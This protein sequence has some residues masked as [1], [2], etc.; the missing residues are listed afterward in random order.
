VGRQREQV[1]ARVLWR[2]MRH[3]QFQKR[4][5]TWRFSAGCT[6]KVKFTMDIGVVAHGTNVRRTRDEYEIRVVENICTELN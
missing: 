6:I 4:W 2:L 1:R 3:H 5:S